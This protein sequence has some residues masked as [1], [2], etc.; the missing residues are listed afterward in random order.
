MARKEST[1]RSPGSQRTPKGFTQGNILVDPNTG[2]PICVKEDLEGQLRLCVDSTV[3]VDLGDV[4]VDLDFKEDSV[5]IGDPVSCAVMKVETDG[6][7]NVNITSNAADGDNIA[8][9]AHPDQIFAQASDSINVSTFKKIFTYTSIDDRTHVTS[10]ECLAQTQCR[11]Q[12]R[13]GATV[14]REAWSSTSQRRV[15]IEFSEH[16]NI[17]SGTVWDVYGQVDRINTNGAFETFVS[18]EGY[19][20]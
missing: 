8:V 16:R 14:I 7:I 18:L 17:P 20:I 1:F 19:L 13:I 6:S 12:L 4:D 2:D 11:F 5:H 15:E 3:N 9:S 10:I